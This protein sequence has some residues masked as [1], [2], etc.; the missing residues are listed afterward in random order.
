MSLSFSK[1]I[2]RLY[3]PI[4]LQSETILNLDKDTEHYVRRVLRLKNGYFIK[5]FNQ[6]DG[7]FMAQVSIAANATY[8]LVKE[9]I[10]KAKPT[11]Y[12]HLGICIVKN[13]VMS[14][15]VDKATQLGVTHITPVIS[16]YTQN[17]EFTVNRYEKIIKEAAEQSGRFD[18]PIIHSAV[19]L[20]DFLS[21]I[22]SGA[23]L[24][25][26]NKDQKP[27]DLSGINTDSNEIWTLIGPEGGFSDLEIQEISARP[28]SRSICLG[29]Y[30][31][32]SELAAIY[33]LTLCTIP[34]TCIS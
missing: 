30:I 12:L 24:I 31:L 9:Q 2:Y 16:Q 7:E 21:S 25:F 34:F 5:V 17:R 22:N 8:L 28:F 27:S 4:Y 3:F 18:V 20:N 32:K 11:R 23:I 14:D 1:H 29:P 26:A 10:R 33:L 19:P 13:A 6:R 15:I